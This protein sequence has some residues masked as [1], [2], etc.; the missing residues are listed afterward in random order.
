MMSR[1]VTSRKRRNKRSAIGAYKNMLTHEERDL[2]KRMKEMADISDIKVNR[3]HTKGQ[4]IKSFIEQAGDPYCLRYGNA[5]IEMT[6]SEEG[7]SL[8][9]SI[10][11]VFI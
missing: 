9:E 2:A 11:A 8:Q 4:R 6:Y 3:A 7:G 5:V 1:T 10:T